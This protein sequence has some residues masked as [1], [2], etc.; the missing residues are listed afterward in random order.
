[1]VNIVQSVHALI[2]FETLKT[3]AQRRRTRKNKRKK[4]LRNNLTTAQIIWT[5]AESEWYI[6]QS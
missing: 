5:R 2:Y 4:Q 1:M 3:S 6:Y